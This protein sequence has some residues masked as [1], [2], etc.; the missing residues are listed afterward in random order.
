[1]IIQPHPPDRH[2][3]E[4]IKQPQGEKG[5]G[6]GQHSMGIQSGAA[7]LNVGHSCLDNGG[8]GDRGG[9]S[10]GKNGTWVV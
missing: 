7:R 6:P 8:R 2:F 3:V 9:E 5:D 10:F 4:A 1:M